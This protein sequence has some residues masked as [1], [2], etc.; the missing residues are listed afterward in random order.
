MRKTMVRNI[1]L[2]CIVAAVLFSVDTVM[3]L[4]LYSNGKTFNVNVR[5][6]RFQSIYNARGSVFISGNTARIEVR[7]EGYKTGRLN[8][9][10]REGTTYYSE[11]IT[12]RNPLVRFRIKDN[13]GAYI[14]LAE[15]REANAMMSD[16]YAFDVIIP[17]EHYSQFTEYDVDIEAS[18]GFVY[19][20]QID[21]MDYGTSR[22][23]RVNIRRRALN[24]DFSNYITVTVP[25]DENIESYRK[26]LV[27]KLNFLLVD[28][29]EEK[30]LSEEAVEAV[31][32]R[33]E[34]LK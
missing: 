34:K 26:T 2:L 17:K 7:A 8:V 33:I 15:V 9:Y 21:I 24:G 23:M 19:G 20:E 12:L 22:K 14:A 11:R 27:K 5:N 31:K 18:A 10:L 13:T 25:V 1:G 30:G 29:K 32:K 28:N 4:S 6:E 3:A 16:M